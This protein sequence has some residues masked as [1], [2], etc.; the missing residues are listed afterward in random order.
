MDEQYS[1]AVDVAKWVEETKGTQDERVRKVGMTILGLLIK[2]SP[3]GDPKRWK[4]NQPAYWANM[5]AS[6]AN[7]IKR[8]HNQHV[9]QRNR[10]LKRSLASSVISGSIS[11]KQYRKLYKTN[12]T[13]G[14]RLTALRKY[15]APEG[16][17][18]G[19][20]RG[21]WQVSFGRPADGEI[22]RIDKTGTATLEAG[23]AILATF[24]GTKEVSIWFT[25][26]VPYARRLEYG[27][28]QQA[29][30]GIIRP[31]VAEVNAKGAT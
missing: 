22:D 29:P 15:H 13:K 26:N 5:T 14:K 9:L 24:D 28:S 18:G 11:G 21:N 8:K 20:F 12:M 1:F 19:R 16:Y 4:V 10:N 30:I 7:A 31:T 17:T 23:N 27:W 3:V 25:N 6:E 2:R